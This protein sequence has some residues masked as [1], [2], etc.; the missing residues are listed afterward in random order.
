MASSAVVSAP[1]T[2]RLTPAGVFLSFGRGEW[3]RGVGE[4]I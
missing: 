4:W 3:R 1:V 2:F